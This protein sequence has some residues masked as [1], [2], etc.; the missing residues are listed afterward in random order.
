MYDTDV[1]SNLLRVRR[2]NNIDAD[3]LVFQISATELGLI[4]TL[5]KI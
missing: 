4:V 2:F 5:L 3:L 1:L